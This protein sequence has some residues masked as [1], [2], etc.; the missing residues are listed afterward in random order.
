MHSICSLPYIKVQ[1]Q[2]F[3]KNCFKQFVMV[4]GPLLTVKSFTHERKIILGK[5]VD[6]LKTFRKSTESRKKSMFYNQLI[7]LIEQGTSSE[8]QLP[9][10]Q[11]GNAITCLKG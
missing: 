3:L 2:C 9:H 11:S 1:V 7:H 10:L 8:P 6:I 5:G 4:F